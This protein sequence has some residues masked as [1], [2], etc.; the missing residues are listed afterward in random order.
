MKRIYF[1]R[2]VFL[3]LMMV[4]VFLSGGKALAETQNRLELNTVMM[5]NTFKIE[6]AGGC[7][8]CFLIGKP[9]KNDPNKLRAIL[10]TAAHVLEGIKSEEATIL[11]RK[12]QSDNSFIKIPYPIKIRQGSDILWTKNNSG[13]DVAVMYISL[14]DDIDFQLLPT[15]FLANDK[16]LKD[17]EIH[18]GDE[19]FCLG[20]PKELEANKAGFPVLRSGKVASY[21]LVP[22][23]N[24]ESFMLDF[25]I[26]PGNSGGPVYFVESNRYYAGS[27]HLATTIQFIAGIVARQWNWNETN[28]NSNKKTHHSLALADIIH[29]SHILETINQLPEEE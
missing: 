1:S 13:Y 15:T 17:F 9:L 19:M 7:G 27:T 8:T 29:A 21:P 22:T 2:V 16:T 28:T 24:E 12:K 6:G 11:L 25:E 14:P 3:T 4:L 20:F 26:F 23:Q 18:P 5:R 10:V